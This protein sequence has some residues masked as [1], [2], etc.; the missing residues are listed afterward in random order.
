MSKVFRLN[1]AD[2]ASASQYL[3]NLGAQ[4]SVTNTTRTTS[5]SSESAGTSSSSSES[6]TTSE[7]DR[8]EAEFYGAAV[9]PLLG[10]IGTTDTRLNTIALI[11][12]PQLIAVAQSY[13]R[14]IDLRKRQVAVKVQILSVSLTNDK[15]ID[16]S[17]SA[18]IGEEAFFVSNSGTAHMN[19][20]FDAW[21]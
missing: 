6:S 9:G 11:G 2:A 13:L 19:L 12:D 8:A 21:R 18:R 3:G 10:L 20:A 14:Q 15:T 4:I 1:Q 5:R 16:S 7:T 17:F